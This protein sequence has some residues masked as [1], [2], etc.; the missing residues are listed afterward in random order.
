MNLDFGSFDFGDFNFVAVSDYTLTAIDGDVLQGT[1]GKKYQMENGVL[2]DF[3][4]QSTYI[5][6][7]SPA[8]KYADDD[9]L[10]M[11]TPKGPPFAK[12]YVNGDVMVG[13]GNIYKM[14][15][16]KLRHYSDPDTYAFYG[17]P[18]TINYKNDDALVNSTPKG[19]P[20]YIPLHDGDVVKADNPMPF[21]V[22]NGVARLFPTTEVYKFYGSPPIKYDSVASYRQIPR[23]PDYNKPPSVSASD[24]GLAE[25]FVVEVGVTKDGWNQPIG[26]NGLT[27]DLNRGIGGQTQ[28]VAW[29]KKAATQLQPD[30]QILTDVRVCADGYCA[31]EGL[32]WKQA[33]GADY[34]GIGTSG[35]QAHMDVCGKYEKASS[36]TQYVPHSDKQSA[37][38]TDYVIGRAACPEGYKVFG[39]SRKGCGGDFHNM[40]VRVPKP[41]DFT[42]TFCQGGNL[43]TD[44]CRQ[45]I[46]KDEPKYHTVVANYCKDNMDRDFCRAHVRSHPGKYDALV[47][48]HCD[49]SKGD[50]DKLCSCYKSKLQKFNPACIDQAC[51]KDGY[52]TNTMQLGMPCQIMN[53]EQKIKV[54]N[55]VAAEGALVDFSTDFNQ[56]CNQTVHNPGAAPV[57][58]EIPGAQEVKT[59][60]WKTPLLTPP[61]ELSFF[62]KNGVVVLAVSVAIVVIL[63]MALFLV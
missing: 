22:E 28:H 26:W 15:N 9:F 33:A 42:K 46:V 17:S 52:V 8:V 62:E 14:E 56:D 60:T 10:I 55:I 58:T 31:N 16:G 40:C 51:I 36:A 1:D 23:G 2:R 48:S 24:L 49:S 50:G 53:C 54:E 21:K 30:T 59:P 19:T 63:T 57:L 41:L 20:F 3:P 61:A 12:A 25:D 32:G 5:F 47:K 34:F 37:F 45:Q 4:D 38:F 13:N 39:D 11:R 44:H 35:C 43:E 6:Y 29:N 7:G 18:P 27:D